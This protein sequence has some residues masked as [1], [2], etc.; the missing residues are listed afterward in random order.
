MQFAVQANGCILKKVMLLHFLQW[1]FDST[2][3]YSLFEWNGCY[4]RL[5]VFATAKWWL[6]T[7]LVLWKILDAVLVWYAAIMPKPTMLPFRCLLPIVSTYLCE[8]GW[9]LVEVNE[10]QSPRVPL[11]SEIPRV[12]PL[13]VLH[14]VFAWIFPVIDRIYFEMTKHLSQVGHNVKKGSEHRF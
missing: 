9:I 10:K 8:Q 1:K 7:W 5:S 11:F 14:L 3:S 12:Y 13:R 4:S 2:I 6:N